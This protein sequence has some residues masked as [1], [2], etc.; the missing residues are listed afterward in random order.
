[1]DRCCSLDQDKLG[2]ICVS[3]PW[4]ELGS[5]DSC[6]KH[7]SQAVRT[8]SRRDTHIRAEPYGVHCENWTGTHKGSDLA[9]DMSSWLGERFG[10]RW[11]MTCYHG[12]VTK[13]ALDPQPALEGPGPSQKVQQW[14][15]NIKSVKR[16]IALWKCWPSFLVMS[17]LICSLEVLLSH[18]YAM[19][20]GITFQ[21]DLGILC[22]CRCERASV[23]WRLCV[24]RRESVT[25]V[26]RYIMCTI[27]SPPGDKHHGCPGSSV[28]H[29]PSHAVLWLAEGQWCSLVM[30]G[31]D[32]GCAV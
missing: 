32:P 21:M 14:V 29:A 26:W 12:T 15:W 1:M 4:R 23:C 20:Y 28:G 22:L 10:W 7:G 18:P 24:N 9:L 5:P 25:E 6:I 27:A 31:S 3:E 30:W 16:E 13:A 11:S 19:F 2:A 17:C 8:V